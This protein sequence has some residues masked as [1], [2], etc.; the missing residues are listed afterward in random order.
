MQVTLDGATGA[1]APASVTD[2]ITRNAYT[3]YGAVRGAKS[4]SIDHGWLNKIADADTGLT[5]LGA[6]YYDPLTSRFISPDPLMNPMDPKTLDAYM[7]ANNNP[8]AFQ[9]PSG[10]TPYYQGNTKVADEYYV[11]GSQYKTPTSTVAKPKAKPRSSSGGSQ[12]ADAGLP[13]TDWLVG[14]GLD[15]SKTLRTGLA[16]G[17]S[18]QGLLASYHEPNRLWQYSW[19]TGGAKG[20]TKPRATSRVGTAC[21]TP[22]SPTNPAATYART[23]AM[24]QNLPCGH[25]APAGQ[26][27]PAVTEA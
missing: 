27:S 4:P 6:R 13:L 5:Y 15:A 20:A 25:V 17:A 21:A 19:P 11:D 14:G 24:G 8:T 10:L 12:G 23:V 3:P 7:Y 2:P 22:Q 16:A 9:D 18:H 26:E 1:M